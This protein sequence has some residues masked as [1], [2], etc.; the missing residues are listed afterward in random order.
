ME[1]FTTLTAIAAPMPKPNINTD[2]IYPGLVPSGVA[3]KFGPQTF[4]DPKLMGPN[5][6]A[7]FRWDAEGEPRADF[8]LNQPPYDQ[9]KILVAGAN[10]GCGSSREM[11]VWAL[12][13]IGVRCII[14]LSFGDIFFNNCFKNGV[15]PVQLPQVSVDALLAQVS[16]PLDP[17]LTVDLVQQTVRGADGRAHD[18]VVTEYYRQALLRGLDEI[19]ATVATRLDQIAAFERGYRD[20][21]S[22]LSF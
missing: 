13:G 11:A 12:A 15:L 18:F 10:F 5:A 3:K 21:R 6:F 8:I 14:A 1:A 17:H 20:Q 9:A 7:N 22:W 19:D 16:G 4:T 2:D